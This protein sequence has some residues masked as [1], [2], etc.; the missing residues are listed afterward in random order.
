MGKAIVRWLKQ[1]SYSESEANKWFEDTSQGIPYEGKPLTEDDRINLSA[2]YNVWNRTHSPASMAVLDQIRPLLTS[3]EYNKY[4]KADLYSLSDRI[5][6]T[7]FRAMKTVPKDSEE[8]RNLNKLVSDW[9]A[10]LDT[11]ENDPKAVPTP[12]ILARYKPTQWQINHWKTL[13]NQQDDWRKAMALAKLKL[14]GIPMK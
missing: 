5:P 10:A 13:A 7:I 12:E 3:K 4:R 1:A 14:Y 6:D 11:S 9:C 2:K 8:Y